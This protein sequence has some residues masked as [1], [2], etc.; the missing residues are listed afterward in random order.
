MSSLNS[1]LPSNACAEIIEGKDKV[2]NVVIL[3]HGLGDSHKSFANMAKNVPLPNTSYISL[4][5]PYRLP[6]DFENPGG[7]WMWGEDVHFDQN[8]ELQSEADFSKSFT[9]IS[10]L[11]GN[12]LSY[13]ILSSRIFFFG[14]GQGA[15]VALYSCYKLSTKYQLGGI[16][17]FGG[18]LPLSITLPNHPFHV[19]VYLFEKRLHCSCSEYEES[20]L[21]KTFKPFHLTCWNRDDKTDM[22]SSPR[23]WY[24]F[25]QSIS[26]HLYIHNTL[27]EDAIPLTSF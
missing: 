25:V 21:R 27:F 13:G 24:T 6:L 22:P 19:P 15:M 2:H 10:N 4:R 7:N 9:M 20:R 17:S 1:V 8:G 14:F 3:M 26:K 12:L 18:T 11:I 23:E 16:F 5:G